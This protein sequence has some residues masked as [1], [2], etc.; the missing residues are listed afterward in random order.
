MNEFFSEKKNINNIILIKK[1]KE[2][3]KKIINEIEK[4]HKNDEILKKDYVFLMRKYLKTMN[5]EKK[6]EKSEKIILE[7][8]KK[9][10]LNEIEK[11]RFSNENNFILKEMECE[12]SN[13]D[14]I[15]R[16]K[17]I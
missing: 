7:E 13:I 4:L 14:E 5:F 8:T 15:L 10:L 9:Y 1:E 12:L 16:E 2:R 17:F 11:L 3:A 6:K